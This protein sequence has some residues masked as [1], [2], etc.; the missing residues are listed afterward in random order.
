MTR[1]FMAL[2]E[3]LLS[4]HGTDGCRK[5]WGYE[6]PALEWKTTLQAAHS[7]R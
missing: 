1:A 2:I 7:S 5:R 4:E 6:L 3:E